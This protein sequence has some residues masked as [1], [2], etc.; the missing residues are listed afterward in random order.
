MRLGP[1]YVASNVKKGKV[2]LVDL[3]AGTI[4][5][6]SI[7]LKDPIY[8]FRDFLGRPTAST[9][10]ALS[11]C[12]SDTQNV[13]TFHLPKASFG[14]YDWTSEKPAWHKYNGYMVYTLAQ[15]RPVINMISPSN[16]NDFN[17]FSINT[18]RKKHTRIIS[19]ISP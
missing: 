14:L 19:N 4:F 13:L 18:C 8:I 3:P 5:F 6:R 10:N 17:R 16:R 2:Q 12:M 15:T 7:E 11:T 1:Y 9:T